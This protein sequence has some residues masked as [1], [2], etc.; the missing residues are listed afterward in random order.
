MKFLSGIVVFEESVI[1]LGSSLDKNAG[2][3][4]I[5]TI[6]K[7]TT[8]IIIIIIVFVIFIIYMLLYIII[9]SNKKKFILFNK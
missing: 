2:L 6:S 1:G 9:F 5:N 8:I 3:S 7:I 4:I